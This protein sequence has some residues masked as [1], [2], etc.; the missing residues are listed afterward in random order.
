MFLVTGASAVSNPM[1]AIDQIDDDT[2]DSW[3]VAGR[4]ARGHGVPVGV[5]QFQGYVG[6]VASR[7]VRE[8]L[9]L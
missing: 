3:G 6:V 7:E 4:V 8:G 5:S 1:L 2:I 9:R